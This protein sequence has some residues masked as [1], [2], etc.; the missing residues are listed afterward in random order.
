M[1]AVVDVYVLGGAKFSSSDVS[2]SSESED[3]MPTE[4]VVEEMEGLG[5]GGGDGGEDGG[6]SMS[7]AAV[8]LVVVDGDGLVTS[9]RCVETDMMPWE[10]GTTT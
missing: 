3:G 4:E 10:P 9:G 7:I 5:E 1:V 8:V 6:W 2:L